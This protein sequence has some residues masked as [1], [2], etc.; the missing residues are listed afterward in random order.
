MR[1]HPRGDSSTF[2]ILMI[3]IP[4]WFFNLILIIEYTTFLFYFNSNLYKSLN[5]IKSLNFNIKYQSIYDLLQ[6]KV[7]NFQLDFFYLN[8][9]H[10]AS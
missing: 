8:L 10:K 6:F 4:N 9:V 2:V 3:L 7:Y 1:L 5:F